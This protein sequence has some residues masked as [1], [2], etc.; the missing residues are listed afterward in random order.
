ML[1][2]FTL[3]KAAFIQRYFPGR[4]EM[5]ERA[6]GEA[7]YRRIVKDLANPVQMQVVTAG[8]EANMLVLAGPGI[9]QDA[10]GR[11]PVRLSLRV[12]RSRRKA[13]SWSASIILRRCLSAGVFSNCWERMPEA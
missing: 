6:T 12:L 2:Y 5:L 9:R 1:A 4:K 10:A 7:S 8:E 3:E 11:S 13:F